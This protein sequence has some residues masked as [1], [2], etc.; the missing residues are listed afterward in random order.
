MDGNLA[1]NPYSL[2]DGDLPADYWDVSL[3]DVSEAICVL[4]SDLATA[5]HNCPHVFFLVIIKGGL[6]F[7]KE[8]ESLEF[9]FINCAFNVPE[10]RVCVGPREQGADRCAPGNQKARPSEPSQ[11]ADGNHHVPGEQTTPGRQ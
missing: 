9:F 2:P 10:H 1:D 8:E 3:S 5:F 4:Q 7:L 6:P 11:R